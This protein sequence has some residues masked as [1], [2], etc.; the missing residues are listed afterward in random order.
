MKQFLIKSSFFAVLSLVF[1]IVINIIFLAVIASTDEDF[2]RRLE[3]LKFENPDF[4]LLVLGHSLAANG[5]DT[6]LLTMSG[7]KSY[8]MAIGG[9]FPKTN[10]I[11]LDEYLEKYKQK[12]EYVLLGLASY[13]GSP[14]KE[15]IQPVV[16]FTMSD[17]KYSL[18]DIPIVRFQWLGI[19][20]LKKA[21]SKVHRMTKLSYGQT[22]F[23]KISPDIT[24]YKDN[25]L[26][27]KYFEDSNY[28]KEIAKRCNQNGIKLIILEM[29]GFKNTQNSSEKGPYLLNFGDGQSAFLY[30][31]NSKDFC[32]IFD[33]EKDWI[34]NSHLNEYGAAKFTKEL[35]EI[36][37][38]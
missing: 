2:I 33:S 7:I 5:I 20:F 13:L 12:P 22:K 35:I 27:I 29:P 3:S 1:F 28:L 8:N 31:F 11:Q 17:H 32:R 30:N 25:N 9:S 16:E 37:K 36:I 34:A 26:N 21:V 24:S 15:T 6:E 23:Q 4:R 19:E 18:K 10:L 38:K 14:D